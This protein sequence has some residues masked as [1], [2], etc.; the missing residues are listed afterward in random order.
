[1]PSALLT[2][3]DSA[4]N[5]FEIELSGGTGSGNQYSAVG[6]TTQTAMQDADT[7]ICTGTALQTGVIKGLHRNPEVDA[8]TPVS[9]VLEVPSC[10]FRLK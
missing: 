8:S 4:T 7:Y 9:F 6:F 3:Q 2:F 10:C 1:M 5:S